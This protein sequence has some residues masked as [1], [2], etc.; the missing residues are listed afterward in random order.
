MPKVR[1]DS[2]KAI[3][4]YLERS[5]RTV[6]RWHAY[7][8]MPVHHFGGCKGSVFAYAEE[9]DR[10]LMS[11]AQESRLS[12]SGSSDTLSDRKSLSDELV[13][14][15][16]EMWE[17]RTE[18]SLHAI[19]GLYRKAIDQNPANTEALTGLSSVLIFAALHETMNG[20]IAYPAATEALRRTA[21]YGADDVDAR[22]A[23]AWLR[24][25]HERK[26]L[27]ARGGFEEVLS[28]QPDSSFALCGMALSHVAEGDL[29]GAREWSWKAW[30][31]NALVPVHGALVC[32]IEY[33][34][35]ASTAAL[36]MAGQ[37]RMSGGCGGTLAIVES[38]ALTQTAPSAVR[39][40][41]I[42][43]LASDHPQ[44]LSLQCILAYDCALSGKL[45][46][47]REIHAAVE[48][49]NA[50]KKRSNAYGMALI[51]MGLGND[52]EAIRW[53]EISFAES[54]LWSLA[55][56]S[57]PILN[58]LR[59]DPRFQALLRRCGVQ[60][61]TSTNARHLELLSRAG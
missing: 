61:G 57:D 54:S 44:S 10:W 23:A 15:A 49:M 4:D 24:L 47:A 51:A 40:K 13:L 34:A 14:R 39:H 48:L 29:D 33:L 26:G 21:Q 2:W 43:A 38:L 35:G 27:Q 52:L 46:R 9:I 55:L 41:R 58:P 18:E 6:Q 28:R 53:L 31:K 11:L 42:F 25:V 7:H 36:D 56:G 12:D 45:A 22:C 3:A 30:Q 32:W 19:A 50:Q 1:L 5:Q 16:H 37:M 59:D 17:S 20:A 60:A 8:G